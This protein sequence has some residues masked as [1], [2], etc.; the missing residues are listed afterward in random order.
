MEKPAEKSGQP[1]I[2]KQYA[3][4]TMLIALIYV[5]GAS[6]FI[7]PTNDNAGLFITVPG[8]VSISAPVCP[9]RF[10][11]GVPCPLCG[12]TTSSMLFFDGNIGGSFRAHPL[13]PVFAMIMVLAIPYCLWILLSPEKQEIKSEEKPVPTNRKTTIVILVVLLMAWAV[14]LMRHFQIINW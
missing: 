7:K 13:G 9:S 14:S 6:F 5:I 12:I 11:T 8:F 3:L 10:L 4:V 2:R 1:S